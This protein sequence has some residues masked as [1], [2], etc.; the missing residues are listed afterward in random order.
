[1]CIDDVQQSCEVAIYHKN[2]YVDLKWDLLYRLRPFIQTRLWI[3]YVCCFG[4]MLLVKASDGKQF[5]FGSQTQTVD[6]RSLPS[7]IAFR[8]HHEGNVH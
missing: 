2:T 4:S 1:M 5:A 8:F 3:N 7:L 6:G